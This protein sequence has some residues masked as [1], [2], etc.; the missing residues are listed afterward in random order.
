ME[1]IINHQQKF[2]EEAPASL[3]ELM[4]L[5]TSRKSKGI[6]VAVNNQ[7][8]PKTQWAS[9]VLQDRDSILIITATQ[10]G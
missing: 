1:L 4:Y 3:A 2:F 5:E 8:V 9:T 7:V 10:G 6:A